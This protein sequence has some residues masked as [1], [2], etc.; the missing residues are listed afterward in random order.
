MPALPWFAGPL[1]TRALLIIVDVVKEDE[2]QHGVGGNTN[3]VR[4]E[5]LVEGKGPS[6]SHGLGDAIQGILVREGAVGPRLLLLDLRRF[7][8]IEILSCRS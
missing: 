6:L 4:G 8:V 2:R 1:K 7:L 5:A 3:V